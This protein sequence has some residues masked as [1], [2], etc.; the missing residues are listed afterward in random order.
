MTNPSTELRVTCA[1]VKLNG[2]KQHYWLAKDLAAAEKTLDGFTS[3]QSRLSEG[4]W[5][6]DEYPYKIQTRT[7]TK[8]VDE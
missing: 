6:L 8:W 1:N 3:D 4:H 2:H 5:R 7:V